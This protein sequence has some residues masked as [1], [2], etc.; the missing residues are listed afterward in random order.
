MEL[1]PLIKA[2]KGFSK[3]DY[4]ARLQK[5]QGLGYLQKEDIAFLKSSF[6]SL[7][8]PQLANVFI[9][10]AIGYFGLPLGV[11]VNFIINGKAY[12]IPL[13]VE[14][15]SVIAAASKTAR[16]IANH[17]ALTAHVQGRLSTGQI[18]IAQVKD[19]ARLKSVIHKRFEDWKKEVH[20]KVIPSMARR[21]GGIKGFELRKI[22]YSKGLMAALHIYMDTCEAMGANTINRVCEF[23]KQPL[24]SEAKETVSMCILSNL[25]D[26]RLVKAQ[27]ELKGLPPEL[28]DRIEEASLFAESDPYR[29]AT[30]NK[31]ALNGMDAL[32]I[33]AGN[34]WRALEAGLHSYA[35]RSGAYSA[36]S[37]WRRRGCSLYGEMEGPL[38]AGV[39]GGVTRLHPTARLCLKILKNPSADQ[40]GEICMA[41]GLAQNLGALRA[42]ASDGVVKGHMRLHSKNLAL[43][44]AGKPV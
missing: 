23:L 34:D 11:A 2:F 33:A 37:R 14:E 41:L 22:P 32:F 24:E 25:A 31:G 7:K 38:M 10:N 4:S 8:G 5:L 17:G 1:H 21:G 44:A 26:R 29:A 27:A 13:A 30:H 42:L 20:E 9:E 35:A 39:V 43:R 15:T 36:L 18:Q 40:L 12:V 19:Y 16:W 6:G 28:M 3:L